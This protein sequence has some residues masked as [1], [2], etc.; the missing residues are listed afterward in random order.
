MASIKQFY[1]RR[2]NIAAITAFVRSRGRATRME[3][4]TAL[5]LS[6]A[7]VSDLVSL[8]IDDEILLE[9]N[10]RGAAETRGRVPTYLV[11]NPAKYFLGIDINDSGIAVTLLSID[12]SRISSKKWEAEFFSDEE[13]LKLT[14]C[15]KIE[16]SITKKENCLGIGVA[17]EGAR[18]ANG[19]WYYPTPTGSFIFY[20]DKV[21]E[22]RFGLPVFVRH[23]PECMLYTVAE[24]LDIDC[25]TLR[26]D[27]GVGVAVMKRGKLME[28]PLELGNIFVGGERLRKYVYD[29]NAKESCTFDEVHLGEKLG[30]SAANLAML[31]GL[32]KVYIVGEI[33][34]WFDKIADEFDAA[35]SKVSRK[36]EYEVSEISDASEGA[37]R[38]AMAAYPILKEV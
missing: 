25:M 5:S 29:C 10:E 8:L 28:A 4:S 15:E 19:G 3:I 23:D 1:E 20:P 7:C 16:E 21:I 11:L 6:W 14:V 30:Y 34:A 33:I 22:D 2:D 31:L 37:A 24:S 26:V 27:T 35:F 17:M 38:V 9:S 18:A 12:G 13:A 32:K 36:I